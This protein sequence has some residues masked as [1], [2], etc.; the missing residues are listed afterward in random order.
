MSSETG[1]P[2]AL[3][4]PGDHARGGGPRAVALVMYGDYECPYTRAA[5][6]NIQRLERRLSEKL[7]FVFRHFPLRAIHPHAQ[8]AAEAAEAAHAQRRF[9]AMHDLMFKR[10]Q[11][12]E[13]QDL[14]SY[15]GEIGLRIEPFEAEL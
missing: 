6:R 12:L 13:T 7:R 9:W 5:Y 4:R 11:A 10:Q 8:A 3:E 1:P 15:A 2:P 14:R